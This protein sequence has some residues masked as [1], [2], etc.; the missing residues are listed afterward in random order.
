[1]DHSYPYIASLTREPFL[2]Y[3]MRCTARLM[4]EG[5]DDKAIVKEIVEQNLFQYPTEKMIDRMA[6]GCVKRLHAL[7]DEDLIRA[8]VLQPTDVAKQVCL[9]AMMKQSRLI[10]EFILFS[11]EN[12][13]RRSRAGMNA[14]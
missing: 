2:F 5:L 8:I 4:S 11:A 6:K 1:M 10:W 14:A 9:Y 3:E 12:L 13:V 7:Q